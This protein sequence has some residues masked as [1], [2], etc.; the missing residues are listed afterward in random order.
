VTNTFTIVVE[1]VNAAPTLE[2]IADQSLHF[3]TLLSVQATAADSDLPANRLTFS[4]DQ[5]PAGLAIDGT[6]GLITWTPAE[7]QVGTF[8]VTIRVTDN[9]NPAMSTAL[10]F[11]ITVTGEGTQLA[12]QRLGGLVQ[13]TITGDIGQIYDLEASKDLQTWQHIADINLTASPHRYVDPDSGTEP[14]RFYR[15]RL[16]GAN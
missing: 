1:E 10:T 2:T 16:R 13:I 4:L 9:G 15:L 3:G 7:T 5:P 6:A 8:P 14:L 11:Q 12:A